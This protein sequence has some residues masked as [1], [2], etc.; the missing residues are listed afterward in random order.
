MSFT[1]Y[2]PSA[3]NLSLKSRKYHVFLSF[4]G[5]DVR[6]SFVDHLYNALI[7]AGINTFLDSE[8]LKKGKSIGLSLEQAIED[9]DMRIPIFSRDYAHSSW[10]LREVTRMWK[11]QGLTIPLFYD[12]EPADVRYP[13]Q[14]LFAEAF[15]KHLQKG[16]HSEE[17][18]DEWKNALS[19]VSSLSGWSLNDTSGYEAKLVKLVVSNILSTLNYMPLRLAKFI[20]G[21]EDR[22]NELESAMYGDIHGRLRISYTALTPQ[23]KEIFLDIACFF[24]GEHRE[25]AVSFWEANNFT[26]NIAITSLILK[27]L[28][29]LN[30]NDQFLMHDHLQEMAKAIVLEESNDPAKRSRLWRRNDIQQVIENGE[31][32]GKVRGLLYQEAEGE[33]EKVI[34]Q[35]KCFPSMHNLK[36]LSLNGAII[37]GNF[38]LLLPPNLQ[39]L[40]WKSCS[41][42]CFPSDWKMKR[43]AVLRLENNLELEELWHGISHL[44]IPQALRALQLNGCQRLQR[45]PEFSKLSFLVRLQL[46]HCWSLKTIPESIGL[47]KDLRLLDLTDCISLE[48]LPHSITKLSSLESLIL[49]DCIHLNLLPEALGNLSALKELRLDATRINELPSSIGSLSYLQKLTLKGSILES[50][51]QSICHLTQLLYLDMSRCYCVSQLPDEFGNLTCLE[52]LLLNECSALFKLPQ[53]FGHLENLRVLEMNH[54]H[55]LTQLP[56]SFSQLKS[57]QTLKAS[58]CNLVQDAL[59]NDIGQLSLLEVL[60]L[61]FNNFRTL[62]IS[63]AEFPQLSKLFLHHCKE[64]Q[65]LPTLPNSLVEMDIG[66]CERVQTISDISNLIKLEVLVLCNCEQVADLPGLKCLHSLTELNISRCKNLTI[67]TVLTDLQDLRSLKKLYLTGCDVSPPHLYGRM[68]KELP[69][70]Q[71][72]SLSANKVPRRFRHKMQRVMVQAAHYEK[73]LCM[74]AL[75]QLEDN[76]NCRGVRLS[77]VVKYDKLLNVHNSHS[78]YFNEHPLCIPCIEISIVRCGHEIYRTSMCSNRHANFDYQFYLCVYGENHPLV[79]R[80][81]NGDMIQVWASTRQTP[82]EKLLVR[83]VDL[84]FLYHS[85]GLTV[86]GSC[87]ED[88][89]GE[90][91]IMSS[92]AQSFSSEYVESGFSGEIEKYEPSAAFR[93]NTRHGHRLS[94]WKSVWKRLTRCCSAST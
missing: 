3:K 9:S 17:T 67:P 84:Q 85:K 10:C 59:P 60:H 78:W 66:D 70:F 92:Q 61:D 93:T 55:D 89:I 46:N 42:V 90:L 14:G 22:T 58:G 51:P 79:M 76:A 54:N 74:R 5:K 32:T 88:N 29:K 27:S 62:P 34:C 83:D 43:L 80:M 52:E 44:K 75:V 72:L 40:S 45:L 20:V 48:Q 25:V 94:K 30:D 86:D 28:I 1:R 41:F 7:T 6:K 12:V 24:I 36:F 71:E 13:E 11:S 23:E 53:S 49:S 37:Q 68:M 64:L 4:R 91:D 15:Q 65:A 8:K 56:A 63:F 47:L 57:L 31:G 77:V 82:E 81:Q 2:N 18:I 69:F 21:L 19:F 16:R 87:G 73:I 26:P 33:E 38:E 35:T 50:L 39:W